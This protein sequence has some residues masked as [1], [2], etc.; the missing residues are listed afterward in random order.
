MRTSTTSEQ[1]WLKLWGEAYNRTKN[2][3]WYLNLPPAS[4]HELFYLNGLALIG[5]STIAF[6]TVRLVFFY[7]GEMRASRSIYT[8]LLGAVTRAP[9][10]FF[11][12]TPQGRI[13]QRF[14]GDMA[15]VDDELPTSTI[16]FLGNILALVTYLGVCLVITPAF[17][18]PSLALYAFGPWYVRGF[19]ASTRGEFTLE[20]SN[21][22][23]T[24]K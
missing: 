12:N 2:L 9:L 23:L 10:R 21:R 24:E 15:V 18:I 7:Y 14:T 8:R 4:G 1:F 19:L 16:G 20:I 13:L 5:L 3:D 6:Q 17:V 11:N 22:A